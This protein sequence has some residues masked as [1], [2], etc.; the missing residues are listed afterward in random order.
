MGVEALLL[1][2]FEWSQEHNCAFVRVQVGNELWNAKTY[3]A[4]YADY[5]A[6]QAVKIQGLEGIVLVVK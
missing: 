5:A 6:G 4:N 1:D 2:T 3:S